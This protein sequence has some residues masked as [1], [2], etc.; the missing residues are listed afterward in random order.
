MSTE[1]PPDPPSVPAPRRRRFPFWKKLIF[2]ALPL[3]ALF[4]LVEGACRA[5]VRPESEDLALRWRYLQRFHPFLGIHRRP[6]GRKVLD[7]RYG[8]RTF[9]TNSLGLRGEEVETRKPEGVFRIC[10]LGGSTTENE[11]VDDRETYCAL[12][13]GLLRRQTA[14]AQIEVVNAGCATYC[15]AHTLINYA[16]RICE[17]D[18]DL[19]TIYHGINDLVPGTCP[20][21]TSDYSHFYRFYHTVAATQTDLHP[22]V[23]PEFDPILDW[24][25]TYRFCKRQFT[26]RARSQIQEPKVFRTPPK[27]RVSGPG[28]PTFER[29]LRA[30]VRLAQSHGAKVLLCTFP[31]SLRE[32]LSSAER[33]NL[34]GFGWFKFLT[35]EGVIDGL[36]RHNV[37][38]ERLANEEGALQ[39]DLD[40]AVPRDFDHFFDACHLRPKGQRIVAEELCSTIL[41]AKLVRPANGST[42]RK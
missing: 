10:C 14:S 23:S 37:I 2:A 38:I 40:R 34:G 30:I 18:A 33:G 16:L 26:R 13:Q 6:S 24:S 29:N 42:A 15:T 5:L 12:L 9:T 17:L 1:L 7:D 21:F 39:C 32:N 3:I 25:A 41:G 20:G 27:S 31:Y 19:I 11:F 28:P 35:I 8:R 36:Q 22:I 4:L